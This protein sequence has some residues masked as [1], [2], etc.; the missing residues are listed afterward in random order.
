MIRISLVGTIALIS[1]I[2]FLSIPTSD[3]LY[4]FSKQPY[5]PNHPL[6]TFLRAESTRPLRVSEYVKTT[7]I[8]ATS[9]KSSAIMNEPNPC[10]TKSQQFFKGKNILVTGASGGLGQSLAFNLAR[11]GA[12]KII[13]S[14]R[15]DEKLKI[16]AD[17]INERS[18]VLSEKATKAVYCTCDL[19]DLDDVQ[20]FGK[21]ALEIC[22]PGTVDV[23]INNGGISSRS[24]F[25]DTKIDVD[26]L[27][28]KV[29]F[30]SGAAL[31]KIVTPGMK[32]KGE[33]T[34]IWTSS[35]QGLGSI[36]CEIIYCFFM[37]LCFDYLFI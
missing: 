16:L 32:N 28:M 4:T 37:A 18:S 35:V 34:I 6:S 13:L 20:Q 10:S 30:L 14:G 24:S 25:L 21:K 22:S 17:Q 33:G 36:F 2:F 11:C 7:S 3:A 19:S 23:L 29:N 1:N 12:A 9:S 5:L 27:L 15:E 26:E 8:L 31:A